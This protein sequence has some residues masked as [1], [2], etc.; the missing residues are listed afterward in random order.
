M[1]WKNIGAKC[2]PQGSSQCL[3]F[4][5]KNTIFSFSSR[6]IST[7]ITREKL[8]NL[9]THIV[10]CH[11]LLRFTSP[12]LGTN[13]EICRPWSDETAKKYESFDCFRK[14]LGQCSARE[15]NEVSDD[16]PYCLLVS[17]ESVNQRFKP[18][19][20]FASLSKDQSSKNH[21]FSNIFQKIFN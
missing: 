16:T 6:K 2:V 19:K 9:I 7:K 20:G 17:S 15:K 1:K 13:K 12:V 4:A 18:A 5:E 10:M 11:C 14:I 3:N 21:K 8:Q